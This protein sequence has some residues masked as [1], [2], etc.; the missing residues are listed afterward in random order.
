MKTWYSIKA[1]AE[2]EYEVLIYDEI[3]LWGITA[4]QF[5][6][7]FKKIP[8]DAKVMLRINS[9]GGDVFDSIAIYNVIKRHAERAQVSG[10]VDGLAA[11]GASIV[12][13][14]ARPLA[15][16]E[17]SFL[18]IHNSSG[19]AWGNAE[20]M[21]GLADVLE[22]IDAALVKTYVARSGQSE[23]KIAALL[24][25]ETWLSAAEA[26]D[27]GLAD[28]VIAPVKLAAR[29]MNRFQNPP[30]VLLDASAAANS[31]AV[32]TPEPAASP[33]APAP[34]PSFEIVE[35]PE[36]IRAEAAAIVKL[37]N[38]NGLPEMACEFF[39]KQARL[40]AVQK[41]FAPAA[42][43]RARC[44]AATMPERA[45]KFIAAGLTPDE[46][47]EHLLKIKAA[48]DTA[49]IDNKQRTEPEKKSGV[50]DAITSQREI[51]AI[52]RN[53]RRKTK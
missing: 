36:V 45:A 4:K 12:A 23:E 7:D 27:L 39:A 18:M 5:I 44:A 16:P 50:E 52:W 33:S 29:A 14:A 38:D 19:L 31:P 47:G 2:G 28:E 15:M 48:L 13:M 53:P 24:S 1:Q 32:Q 20:D 41:F 51:Y 21:R 35:D 6:D 3:G 46:V 8:A 11:S 37:C 40:D 34:A 43:I 25:A 42:D 49:D 30:K 22:K 17:N 9:P 26:K 10:T